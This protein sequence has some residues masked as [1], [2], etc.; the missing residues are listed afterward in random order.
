VLVARTEAWGD[1]ANQKIVFYDEKPGIRAIGTT[2]PN[3]APEPGLH[4]TFARS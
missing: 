4:A 3:L 1:G 2:A